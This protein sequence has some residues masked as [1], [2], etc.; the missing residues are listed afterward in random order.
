MSDSW[1]QDDAGILNILAQMQGLLGRREAP[2][3]ARL[4][5]GVLIKTLGADHP[6]TREAM[7]HLGM[8]IVFGF[9][10]IGPLLRY[11]QK[12]YTMFQSVL[13]RRLPRFM[14]GFI[15]RRRALGN[16]L[17]LQRRRFSS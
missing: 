2:E 10:V 5:A 3:T 7:P 11:T 12:L 8:I 14:A 16:W 4:A 9:P 13:W 1:T 15:I 6:L 17:S